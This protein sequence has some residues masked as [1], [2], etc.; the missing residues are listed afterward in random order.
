MT[1]NSTKV[2]VRFEISQQNAQILL[3]LGT[4]LIKLQIY[5]ADRRLFNQHFM[6]YFPSY[7]TV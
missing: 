6:Q 3:K 2:R 4:A 7:A 1:T 5:S